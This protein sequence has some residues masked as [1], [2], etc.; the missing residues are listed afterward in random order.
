MNEQFEIVVILEGIVETT[1]KLRNSL[2]R[3]CAVSFSPRALNLNEN[4]FEPTQHFQQPSD[5]LFPTL[6]AGE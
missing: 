5:L 4:S 6:T 2:S 3:F 1:G